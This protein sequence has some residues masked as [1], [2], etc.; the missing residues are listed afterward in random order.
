MCGIA[1]I[2][3]KDPPPS[4]GDIGAMIADIAYR[5]PDGAG[6]VCFET[7]GIALGHRRLSVLD[8]TEAGSQPMAS[9]GWP[10]L[11]LAT[12]TRLP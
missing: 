6:Q 4:S 5:G 7:D 1:G 2:I 3:S 9:V 12:T 10:M 8:L 11:L